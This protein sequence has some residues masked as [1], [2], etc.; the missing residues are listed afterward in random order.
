M[1]ITHNSS[2]TINIVSK[3]QLFTVTSAL[4][5]IFTIRDLYAAD[6][7]DAK[8]NILS[9]PIVQVGSTS[10]TDVDVHVGKLVEIAP[11]SK[12]DNYDIFDLTNQTLYIADVLAAG[13]SYQDVYVTLDSVV[14]FGNSTLPSDNCEASHFELGEMGIPEDYKGAYPLPEPKAILNPTIRRIIDLKDLDPLWSQPT[15]VNCADDLLY[16]TNRF[17][18][19]IDRAVQLNV[20]T[21]L[22]YNYAEWDDTD[23]DLWLLNENDYALPNELVEVIVNEAHKRNLK[24]NL[25]WQMNYND[26]ASGFNV[27]KENDLTLTQFKALKASYRNH[28]ENYIPFLQEVGLDGIFVDIGYYVPNS[29][30]EQE[31]IDWIVDSSKWLAEN[32]T[33]ALSYGQYNSPVTNEILENIDALHLVIFSAQVWSDEPFSIAERENYASARMY[34]WQKKFE[35]DGVNLAASI[36][37]V[38]EIYAQSTSDFY[39]GTGYYEDSFCFDPCSQ[40][41]LDTDFSMQAI[42]VEGSL[43]AIHNQTKFVNGGVAFTNYWIGDEILPTEVNGQITFP[44][45]SSSIRNKSAEKIVQHWFSSP[46]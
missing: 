15:D 21:I 25:S 45:I 1:K 3:S 7:Y 42:A 14:G 22:I 10:Y 4:F 37:I 24:V 13:E 27:L 20:D 36:P 29:E 26:K 32:F 34:N 6:V 11:N 23:K 18:E 30:Y 40:K 33:G 8:T 35:N 28:L 44:N 17:I 5:L 2:R 12:I 38:W 31:Y 43:R 19:S 39:I 9:I 46:N 41:N 16:L